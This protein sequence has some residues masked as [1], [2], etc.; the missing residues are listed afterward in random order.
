MDPLPEDVARFLDD[1]IESIEQLEILRVLGEDRDR[2]WDSVALADEVQA[3]PEAVRAHVK[4]MHSRGLLRAITKGVG[5]SCRYG[6]GTPELETIVG[7][8]LQIYRERPVTM[9]KIVYDESGSRP[10]GPITA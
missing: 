3:K 2:E 8:L 10:F 9:I 5:L 1:H 7:R 4:A 6:A